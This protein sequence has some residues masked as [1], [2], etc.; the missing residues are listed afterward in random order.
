MV[1]KEIL[2]PDDNT[3][4][5][6]NPPFVGARIMSNEQKVEIK[7]LFKGV[8]NAGNLDYVNGW[9]IKSAKFIENTKVKV[10]LV[11]TSSISQGDQVGILW[12]YLLNE[13]KIYIY[14][15]YR[16]FIWTNEAKGNAAV[17][18]VIIGF[19]KVKQ[20]NN[21]IFQNDTV[22]NVANIN[23][24]LLDAPNIV[25][26]SRNTPSTSSMHMAWIRTVAGRLKS[27]YRYSKD[28]VI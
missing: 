4:I 24:Y 10:G 5:L 3:I 25:G 11:Y 14:F 22:I 6:G 19:S 17:H 26:K 23:P 20:K 18:C 12:D 15:V 2:I 27:D 28:I 1:W 7:E 16:S 13:H 21:Y 8:K 9:Y